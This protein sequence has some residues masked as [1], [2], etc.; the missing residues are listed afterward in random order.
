MYVYILLP[1]K[2][3]TADDTTMITQRPKLPIIMIANI[4]VKLGMPSKTAEIF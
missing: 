3:Y 2:P 4:Y 1:I